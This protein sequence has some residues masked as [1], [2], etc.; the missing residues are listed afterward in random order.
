VPPAGYEW[1]R[2]DGRLVDRCQLGRDP[3]GRVRRIRLVPLEAIRPTEVAAAPAAAL[4]SP[5]Q[6]GQ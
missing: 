3:A 4:L 6:I 5:T 2:D 1:V